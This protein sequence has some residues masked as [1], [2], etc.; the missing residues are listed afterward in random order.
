MRSG[1]RP[2]SVEDSLAADPAALKSYRPSEPA[3]EVT[4]TTYGVAVDD[5]E[6]D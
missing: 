5:E 6:A 4:V 3:N 1:V 2:F